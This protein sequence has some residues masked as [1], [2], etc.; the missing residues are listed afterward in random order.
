MDGRLWIRRVYDDHTA[1]GDGQVIDPDVSDIDWS[2]EKVQYGKAVY[3]LLNDGRWV[4][5]VTG[6]G[7][8]GLAPKTEDGGKPLA[9][10][11][12]VQDFKEIEK[13]I[14]TEVG[15]I[16]VMDVLTSL[17]PARN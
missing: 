5:S 3:K 2:S 8:L 6:D 16:T 12:P 13:K 14:D 17:M 4:V 15:E 7:S 1:P 11:P 9:L 10:A